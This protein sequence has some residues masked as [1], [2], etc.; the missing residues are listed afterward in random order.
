MKRLAIIT[1]VYPPISSS[2]SIQVK[3]LVDALVDFDITLDVYIA[4]PTVRYLSIENNHKHRLL[5]FYVPKTDGVGHVRRTFA[6]LSFP[7]FITYQIVFSSRKINNYDAIVWHSPTIFFGPLIFIFRLF[8][9][10]KTYLIIRDIFPEWAFNL[11]LIRNKFVFD[12]FKFFA[13]L[14]YKQAN[15]IG[16][17]SKG[18]LAY[19][20]EIGNE[21]FKKIEV[22]DNWLQEPSNCSYDLPSH[23][24]KKKILVY[25]GNVGIAQDLDI[26]LDIALNCSEKN[27]I[28]LIIGRGSNFSTLQS[29]A[30][31]IGINNI[32]FINELDYKYMYSIHS[33]CHIGLVFLNLKHKTHNIPG[34]LISYLKAGLP[35]FCIC[36][37]GSDLENLI[38]SRNLGVVF[39]SHNIPELCG[40]I[41][42]LLDRLESDKH[43]KQHCKDAANELFSPKLAATKILRS[44]ELIDL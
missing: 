18:D 15:I 39:S 4:D 41:D 17:Q 12:F 14:Q 7:L 25:S 32:Y 11:G 27:I 23:F 37:K 2:A 21:N 22:L 6:E 38:Q 5:R 20:N 3:N 34:K 29:K 13:N 9:K 10:C 40:G 44:V 31:I 26:L 24:L 33:Q 42:S 35:V 16:V 36:N 28:F 8:N 19:F 43:F 1:S 30:K